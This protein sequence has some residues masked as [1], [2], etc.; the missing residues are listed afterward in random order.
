MNL[1]FQIV[2][3][4]AKADVAAKRADAAQLLIQGGH[5]ANPFLRNSVDP[6]FFETNTTDMSAPPISSSRSWSDDASKLLV[7]GGHLAN[8]FLQNF[9]DS[10]LSVITYR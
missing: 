9:P 10:S 5:L 4:L 8:P 1:L 3:F 7:E 6:F 2:E